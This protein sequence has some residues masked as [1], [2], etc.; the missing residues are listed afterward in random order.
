MTD[1]DYFA[2]AALTR[3]M[4]VLGCE[5][6]AKAC[7]AMADAMLRERERTN[8]D[9]VPEAIAT[10]NGGT[11]KDADGTGSTPSKAEI[12]AIECVVE[13][14]RIASMSIYGVMRSL[15]VRLRPEWESES[16]EKSDEKHANTNTNRDTPPRE[17]SVQGEGTVAPA[18]WLAVAADGSES[19]AV[20]MLKEQADA[21]AR[22]WGWFVVPLY[23]SPTLTD[24]EREAIAVA[25][26]GSLPGR[27]ATLRSLLERLS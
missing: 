6:I 10:N 24:E 8:H 4:G 12:D 18:A 1:R 17:G 9:A 7:Y 16:Y 27:A 14:G 26:V 5:Q 13:D 19:S 20:Y 21:A 23:R 15:L 25:I 11:P 22:E 3:G 2:A